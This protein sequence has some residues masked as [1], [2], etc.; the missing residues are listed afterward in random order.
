MGILEAILL[1]AIQG[2]T[3]FLPISSSGHLVLAQ[4]LLALEPGDLS[5]EVAVHGGTLLAVVVYFR[6]R[7]RSMIGSIFGVT[8]DRAQ[9]LNDIRLVIYI[10]VGT[11]PAVVLGLAFKDHVEQLFASP[12]AAA[13]ALIVTGLWLL[14]M[15]LVKSSH[16]E[17]TKGR[18]LI[19]GLAQAAAIVPG[20]SRSGATIATGSMLGVPA[21]RA[22]EF[23]FLLSVPAIFGA[24]LLA[25]P[26]AMTFGRF[27]MMHVI[28]AVVAAIV[29][30]I[31]IRWVFAAIRHG[32]FVWFGI[33]CLVIG[34]VSTILLM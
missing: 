19:I 11:I 23:S 10:V 3:E 27:G 24:N 14:L 20:I 32:N 18:A 2:L 30:Y 16:R 1:G 6:S 13:I 5:F 12:I 34:G 26:E 9:R 17:L 7:V 21:A 15:R 33:Y 29:G 4:R 22:A 28:G 25:V 31:S 8:K